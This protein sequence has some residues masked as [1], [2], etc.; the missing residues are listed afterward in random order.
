MKEINITLEELENKYKVDLDELINYDGIQEFKTSKKV[1]SQMFDD[2][3]LFYANYYNP[4]SNYFF[5][6]EIESEDGITLMYF[7]EDFLHDEYNAE[8]E[9]NEDFTFDK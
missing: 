4:K 5:L 1:W 2:G 7:D 8:N 6:S 3:E 9:E